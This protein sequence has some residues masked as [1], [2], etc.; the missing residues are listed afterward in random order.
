MLDGVRFKLW[1]TAVSGKTDKKPGT[2]IESEKKLVIACA[3]NTSI[4]LVTIQP[5]GK[6]RMSALDYLRGHSV[7]TGTTVG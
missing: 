5:E 4:E 3:D 1:E 2:V 7:S 6:K